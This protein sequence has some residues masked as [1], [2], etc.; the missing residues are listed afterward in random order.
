[1]DKEPEEILGAT[2]EHDTIWF[3]VKWKNS[4]FDPLIVPAQFAKKTW[5]DLVF[6]FYEANLVWDK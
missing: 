1:L 2:V 5:P 3:L 6:N 4:K